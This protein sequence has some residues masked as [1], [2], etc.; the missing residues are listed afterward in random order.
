[1]PRVPVHQ[2]EA[3][4]GIGIAQVPQQQRKPGQRADGHCHPWAGM[5]QR[6]TPVAQHKQPGKTDR[7]HR[8]EA[9]MRQAA[10]RQA[11]R[12]FAHCRR[13]NP[14]QQA[15]P[16]IQAEQ[17]RQQQR[18]VGQRQ[19]AQAAG[20][21]QQ[22]RQRPGLPAGAFAKLAPGHPRHQPRERRTDQQERQPQPQRMLAEHLHAQPRQPRGQRRQVGIGPGRM[23]AFLP[24]KGL[25]Y[26]QRHPHR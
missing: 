9:V 26:K 3:Q 1:M 20:Q 14:A 10:Q 23:L 17:R 19:Q 24:V 11:K 15:Q 21:R 25:V 7:D 12:Q 5:P 6:A 4:P 8:D 18:H 2:L 16:G 22:Q 13:V